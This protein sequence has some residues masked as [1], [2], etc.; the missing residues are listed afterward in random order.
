MTF[1][2]TYFRA[3]DEKC[4]IAIPKPL[5]G[6]ISGEGDTSIYLAPG[7]DGC[8]NLY[9]EAGFERLADQLS[10]ASPAAEDVRAF[11]RLFYGQAERLPIDRQGRIRI[12][13]ELVAWAGLEKEVAL[14]GVRDHLEVWER[15]RW[16]GYRGSMRPR[17]DEIAAGAFRNDP[18]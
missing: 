2:G 6:L 17:Y 3:I 9:T 4:R 13:A 11:S 5:R 15:A 1:S 12:S 16:E 14:V 7:T 18:K 8:L 10:A